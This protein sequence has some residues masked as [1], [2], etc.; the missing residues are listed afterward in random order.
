MDD[1]LDVLLISHLFPKASDPRAG[2][3]VL[4]QAEALRE[5]G[6]RLTVVSPLPFI[7]QWLAR[8][9]RWRKYRHRF[10][11]VDDGGFDVYQPRYL[12]PPGARYI[13]YEGKAMWR[14][15]EHP[16]VETNHKL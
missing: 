2:I 8:V 11:H 16:P 10:D 6:H 15:M 9:P 12:R 1:T 4:R 7:P 3:F 5:L 13:P 14:S